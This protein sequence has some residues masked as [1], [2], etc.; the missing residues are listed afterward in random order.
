[1]LPSCA[2]PVGLQ[3][4]G[5]SPP[6]GAVSRVRDCVVPSE[7][8]SSLPTGKDPNT[9]ESGLARPQIKAHCKKI[10]ILFITHFIVFGQ[11]LGQYIWSSIRDST[12]Q[13]IGKNIS[14][15]SQL[16]FAQHFFDLFHY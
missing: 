15:F 1:L 3:P 4:G 14:I 16:L 10:R 2:E 8:V 7:T 12:D 13:K 9:R 5:L 6:K 11:F